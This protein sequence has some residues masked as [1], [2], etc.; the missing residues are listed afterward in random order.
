MKNI[1]KKIGLIAV[2]IALVL[3]FVKLPVAKADTN[4]STHLQNYLFLDFDSLGHYGGDGYTTYARFTKAFAPGTVNIKSIEANYVNSAADQTKFWKLFTA[5]LNRPAEYDQQTGLFAG[6]IF[7]NQNVN[8]YTDVTT[9]V[10]SAWGKYDNNG[11]AEESDWMYAANSMTGEKDT[12]QKHLQFGDENVIIKPA[13]WV[14]SRFQSVSSYTVSDQNLIDYFE[15][16]AND[17]TET[18]V[19]LEI[20][21][22]FTSSVIG[23]KVFGTVNGTTKKKYGSNG[24]YQEFIDQEELTTTDRNIDVP[25]QKDGNWIKYYWPFILSVEYEA[26]NNY[27]DGTWYLKY[28]GNADDATGVPSD[29]SPALFNTPIKVAKGTPSK[30]GWTFKGWCLDSKKCSTLYQEGQEVDPPS[31]GNYRVLYAQWGQTGTEKNNKTGIVSYIIGFISVG[32]IAAV[33]YL[34]T[35]RKNLFKQI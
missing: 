20:T 35:K 33:I 17:D 21:R 28:D 8:N 25:T 34:V 4:C 31:S 7:S 24:T 23:G 3:P 29:S 12:L 26:C 10:H 2:L 14:G 1:I 5:T 15:D 13:E 32:I 18:W 27:S 30:E 11:Q 6:Y 22:K 16:L 19:Y 9:L